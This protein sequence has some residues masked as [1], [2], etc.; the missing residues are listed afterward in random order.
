MVKKVATKTPLT[1]DEKIESLKSRHSNTYLYKDLELPTSNFLHV[2]GEEVE[3]GNLIDCKVLESLDNGKH[4]LISYANKGEK[5][6]VK[7]DDGLDYNIFEWFSVFKKSAIKSTNV[8]VNKS[9]SANSSQRQLGGLIKHSLH[10]EYIVNPEYQRGYVWSVD[11]KKKYIDS[12][13]NERELGKFIFIHH[14]HAADKYLE[15]LDGKQRISALTSFVKGEFDYKGLYWHELSR[16]DRH[17]FQDRVIPYVEIPKQGLK[18]SE[19]LTI[20]LE[21]NVAGVPQTDEHLDMVRTLKEKYV[22]DESKSK[23]KPKV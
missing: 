1:E 17:I 18:K 16:L 14:G 13:M 7:Y 2:V 6:G 23:I 4:Y 12:V 10:G 21:V 9:W 22:L 5:Y 20:F 11:D 3:V 8:V 19:I 15:I